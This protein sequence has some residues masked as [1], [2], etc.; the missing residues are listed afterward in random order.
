MLKHYIGSTHV[1]Q[2]APQSIMGVNRSISYFPISHTQ[3]DIHY[4]SKL[5]RNSWYVPSMALSRRKRRPCVGQKS[6]RGVSRAE[7]S[8]ECSNDVRI[9]YICFICRFRNKEFGTRSSLTC[10]WDTQ[11][12]EVQSRLLFVNCTALNRNVE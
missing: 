7:A 6:R 5:R 9:L 2:Q 12:A 10:R 1:C 8:C 11:I 3:I 4:S